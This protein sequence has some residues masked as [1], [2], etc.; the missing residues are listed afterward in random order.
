LKENTMAGEFD[1]IERYFSNRQSQR[2]DVLLSVGDDC[3]LVSAPAGQIIAISTDTCVAG[4]H[5]LEH[6]NPAW[7]AH[8]ALASNISD[9]A[10][11]G[12][13]PAWVSMAIT[14]PELSEAWL[15]P[16]CDA[17]FNL[18]NQYDIQ[19]IGGDTTKGPLSISL[20]VQGLLNPDQVLKRDGAKVG[21]KIFVSGSL[22][23][24]K[25]GLDIILDPSLR[26]VP[27]AAYLEMSHYMSTPRVELGKTISSIA[28]SCIDIS[29]GL[30]ADLG[31]ILKRSCV[32]ACVEVND[33]PICERLVAYCGSKIQAQQYALSSGEEY[34][35]CFTIPQQHLTH[36]D[37][38]LS[39][40]NTQVTCIGEIIEGE[41]LQ[42]NQSG[43]EIHWNLNG[44]DH[45]QTQK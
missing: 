45:F 30:I 9:L 37:E 3:A 28:S 26:H 41:R 44:F 8:K 29:D 43:N 15:E 1:L 25:A 4:T 22:G 27:D 12:A 38:L 5:F 6:A 18:A 40:N 13:T 35:I 39:A 19:L 33:L 10:A 7:V 23:L 14:L 17:F 31:H 32:G 21:D 34:E 16:F 20:T 11:M 2:S 24:A 36:F 42:L